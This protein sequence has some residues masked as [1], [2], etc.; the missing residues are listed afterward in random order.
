MQFELNMDRA[1]PE[2]VQLDTVGA[3]SKLS[4]VFVRGTL[5]SSRPSTDPVAASIG[6][7]SRRPLVKT[8]IP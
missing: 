6:M 7:P 3:L 1:G 2:A 8:R 5:E 4:R